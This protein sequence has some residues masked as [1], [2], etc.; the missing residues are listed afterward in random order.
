MRRVIVAVVLTLVAAPVFAQQAIEIVR[1]GEPLAAVVVTEDAPGQ[2]TAAAEM[3]VSYIEQ[4]SGATLP[5]VTEPP[6]A[7]PTIHVGNTA[8]AEAAGIDQ[9]EL[10]TDGFDIAFPDASTIVIL[11]A[12][13]WGTEFGVCDF[14]ERYVGV[15]WVLPGPDG[16]HVPTHDVIA[17]PIEPVRSEPTFFSRQM[18]GFRG[19]AQTEWARRNRMH[20]RVQF[21]HNLRMLFNWETYPQTHPEFFPIING[22]RFL[23]TQR[24]GWQPCFTAEG[25]V[26]EAVRVITAYFD[27]DP[28]RTSYSLGVND[29]RNFCRCDD[30]MAKLTGKENFLGLLDYSELY[31]EWCNEVVEGVLEHH[32]DKFFGL[33]AY[34]NV[35]EP[36]EG[37]DLHPHIIPYMTYDRMK[38]IHPEIEEHG[39]QLTRD[40][41][42]KSPTVGWYDYIYGRPYQLPRV[43]F[44]H[45]ADYYRFGRDNSVQA[46]YAEAYPNWGEGPKLYVAFKLQ[47]D[48]D[49]SVDDLLQE[50]YVAC[51]GEQAA[52]LLA[53]YYAHWEDFWTRRI[54]DSPWFR[55]PGQYLPHRRE[56]SYL[57]E[58]TEEELAQ[59]RGWLEQALALTETDAQQARVQTLL[60]AFSFYEASALCYQVA[61]L[62]QEPLDDEAEALARL[63]RI[64]RAMV[65]GRE[66]DR[67]ANEVFPQNPALQNIS[68]NLLFQSDR[69]QMEA[70]LSVLDYAAVEGGETADRVRELAAQYE[71]TEV[72]QTVS[73]VLMVHEEPDRLVER[74]VN[75]SFEEGEAAV[76]EVPAALNWTSENTPP[77]W[78]RWIRPGTTAEMLW[79]EE[80]ARTGKRSVKV[81]GATACSFLQRIDVE[82]G[83]HY[84]VSGYI[85]ARVSEGTA[86]RINVQWQDA[87]GAWHDAPSVMSEL[88]PGETDGWVRR[89]AFLRV[90]DGAYRAVLGLSVQSQRPGD[91]AFFDDMSFRQITPE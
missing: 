40:W 88:Q 76:D 48:P 1:D 42:E 30:C 49:R 52:P 58:V 13:P 91:Y 8:V 71:G 46:L 77:G 53:N 3:L 86:T 33:L 29:N 64:E 32:P 36:P 27:E 47:W 74:I 10:D 63:D 14:L 19:S 66:R 11:G 2:V 51:G 81:T 4:S 57:L 59:C 69:G 62:A 65:L 15:R 61:A 25:S 67:L 85:R 43:W 54:L 34:I 84:V 31:Y 70:L 7:G 17:V 44:H 68:E 20:G 5:I 82:P 24:E 90:P 6:D 87:A 55:I 73:A 75:G 21:H 26:E 23:P 18:S 45:M 38:W 39:K 22:E 79:T 60:D 72:A 56:P 35:I 37:F 41:A 28:S 83:E 78:S 50:W 80:D 9:A 12:G 16:T 89:G